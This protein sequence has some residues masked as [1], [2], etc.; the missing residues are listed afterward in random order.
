[1]SI[2]DYH[3]DAKKEAML[4]AL[5]K[6]LGIVTV[7]VRSL[8][9]DPKKQENLRR[10]H[11]GWID[12]DPEY[13]KAVESVADIALD[14]AESKLHKQIEKE[15]TTATIFYLKTKGKNRGY[16]ERQELAGPD[17]KPIPIINVQ[18]ND[19]DQ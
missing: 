9:T 14:F 16:I 2:T 8:E 17:G 3:T 15:D 11:Y 19:S 10:Y 1:M 13:K 7:A 5:R 12:G 4:E 6:S 18:Q